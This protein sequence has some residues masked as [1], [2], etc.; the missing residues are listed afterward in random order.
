MILSKPGQ[1]LAKKIDAILESFDFVKVHKMMT[2][3]GWILGDEPVTIEGL[4]IL[5]TQHFERLF[6]DRKCSAIYS[7]GLRVERYR[8]EL[9]HRQYRLL[10]IGES[11]ESE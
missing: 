6:E 11:Q 2:A 3:V 7:G 1:K 9:G 10:F 5:A 8:D 4:K